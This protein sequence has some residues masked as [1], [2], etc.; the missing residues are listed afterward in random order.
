MHKENCKNVR[1]LLLDSRLI[2]P[3]KFDTYNVKIVRCNDYIQVY[4]YSDKKVR[5]NIK[6]LDINSLKFSSPGVR[7]PNA[8]IPGQIE[9][10]NIIRTKLNCQ[11]LAKANSRD[12]KSFI[13]LTYAE[14][15]Q[16]ILK[17]KKDL[18]YL[19]TNV[20][21]Y[22]KDFKYIAIPE[23][24]KR[25]SIHFHLLTNLSKEDNIIYIQKRNNKNYYH[26]KYWKKGFTKVDFI[27][28]DIKKIIS[29]ISK[30]MTKECDN[31]LFNIKRYTSSQ[32]LIKPIDE[33]IDTSI[34]S[35]YLNKILK[36]KKVIYTNSYL[37]NENN[38]VYF[39]EYHN[40]RK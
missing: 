35:N 39:V 38:E 24:Q 27:C 33:F 19:V 14:N 36:D 25:G 31:R 32:N 34:N 29:Y 18:E 8:S 16:D 6:N 28:N 2:T 37:D 13:T 10:R 26:I 3:V 40:E 1:S 22:K 4:F 12:W 5:N 11:R 23:F 15:M 17:A 20:K 9:D 21:K 7:N 30:Y